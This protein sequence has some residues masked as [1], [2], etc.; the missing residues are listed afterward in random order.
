M[1]GTQTL[2]VTSPLTPTSIIVGTNPVTGLPVS[3]EV[4]T[5]ACHLAPAGV[6]AGTYTITAE[7]PGQP[8]SFVGSTSTPATLVV[9]SAPTSTTVSISSVATTFERENTVT[10][11]AKVS[12][13]AVG[14]AFVTGNVL[15]RNAAR[16]LCDPTL[17]NGVAT[18]KLTRAQLP[19]GRHSIVAD[20]AG[21]SNLIGSA[22]EPVTL[23][24]AKAPTTI[25][26]SVSRGTVRYGSEK[27]V[28]IT[29][30][31]SLPAD[32]APVGGRVVVMSGSTRICVISL[33]RDEGSCALT[34]SELAVGPHA[35]FAR[36]QGSTQLQ[37]SVSRSR[38]L[39]VT[40][41]VSSET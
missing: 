10:L 19:V 33:V 6:G 23:N 25:A 1:A 29:A 2:C 24:V 4:G 38:M 27:S 5:A 35:L 7:F 37:G 11:T 32:M 18:C 21:T 9:Q 16:E 22:S 14:S 39:I 40:K 15:I 26:L 30:R 34:A 36:Y 31:L 20:Y 3:A 12:E 28:K 13:P 17:D 41:A 8:G